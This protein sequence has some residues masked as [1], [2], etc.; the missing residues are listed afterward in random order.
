MKRAV[1]LLGALLVL[2]GCRLDV[3]VVVQIGADGTGEVAVTATADA[4]VVNQ[5]PG[6]AEDLRF[7]DAAAAGWIVD[8][9]APTENGGLTMTLRH[10]VASAEEA[11][12]LLASLGPP[13]VDVTLQ[14]VVDPDDSERV[15]VR[16][17][18]QLQ[19]ADGFA[20]FADADLTAAVGG[21]PFAE[22]L[23]AAGATPTESMSV[24]FT[25][26]LPGVVEETTATATASDQLKW[27]APLDGTALDLATR[28]EQRP[29][30]GGG[31]AGPLSWLALLAFVA[32]TVLAAVVF[33]AVVRAR[34]QRRNRH[35][36][37]LRRRFDDR[38]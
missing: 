36:A 15:T 24:T 3:A 9:P 1:L 23:A 20:T 37:L 25:A 19:L 26:T 4:D 28:A 5:A 7:D 16:L 29:A 11:S 22:D 31:W 12:N 21:A 18:G 38:P 27:T 17:A 33:T 10:A 35:E 32:W 30:R 14:R 13:F 6:L 34:A 2:A 8:G